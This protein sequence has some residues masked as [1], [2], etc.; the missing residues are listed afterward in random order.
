MK[1]K[2]KPIRLLFIKWGHGIVQLNHYPF[3]PLL[4]HLD[5]YGSCSAADWP[6]FSIFSAAEMARS[7]MLPLSSSLT[8]KNRSF[9][10]SHLSRHKPDLPRYRTPFRTERLSSSAKTTSFSRL[11]KASPP[12]KIHSVAVITSQF[13]VRPAEVGCSR[14]ARRAQMAKLVHWAKPLSKRR[15]AKVVKLIHFCTDSSSGILPL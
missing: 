10:N 1:P 7:L 2:V 5:H 13:M 3:A 14:A 12:W 8:S 15:A 9:Q 11:N 4:C 6:M